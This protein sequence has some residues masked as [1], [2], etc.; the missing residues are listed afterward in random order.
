MFKL[1]TIVTGNKPFN[2][3]TQQFVDITSVGVGTHTFNYQDIK[4]SIDGK[5]GISTVWFNT[6]S[7]AQFEE[8]EI[9]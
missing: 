1:S 6:T 5:I 4:V 8:T 7:K 9:R 3:D 2:Y